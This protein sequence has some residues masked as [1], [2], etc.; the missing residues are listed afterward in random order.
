MCFLPLELR[1]AHV[2]VKRGVQ[3]EA[4]PALDPGRHRHPDRRNV[5]VQPAEPI[6]V[7]PDQEPSPLAQIENQHP[8]LPEQPR[9]V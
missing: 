6:G 3:R 4:H 1:P 5:I 8:L 9:A 7:Q 2:E